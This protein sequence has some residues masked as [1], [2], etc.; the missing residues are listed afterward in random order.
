MVVLERESY[1]SYMNQPIHFEKK[2]IR[3]NL[4]D[5]KS[6]KQTVD[7]VRLVDPATDLKLI[8][9]SETLFYQSH[10]PFQTLLLPM[11]V[12][13]IIKTV[14]DRGFGNGRKELHFVPPHL[15]GPVGAHAAVCRCRRSRDR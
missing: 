11:R 15:A 9:I 14:L 1:E 6:A 7:I 2:A 5:Y 13:T 10:V 4:K 12:R 8:V 3:L